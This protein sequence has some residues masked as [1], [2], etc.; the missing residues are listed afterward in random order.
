[1]AR[2]IGQ[3]QGAAKHITHRACGA[4]IEYFPIDVRILR[5][6]KDISGSPDGAKGFNCPNCGQEVITES[7]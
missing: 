7:W 4:V 2:V 5:Q 1:M 6:G 3:D